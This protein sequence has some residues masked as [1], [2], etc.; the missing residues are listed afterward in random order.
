MLRDGV[1]QFEGVEPAKGGG[2]V[3]VKGTGIP[4]V[5]VIGYNRRI[6]WNLFVSRVRAVV[7]GKSK[8][9]IE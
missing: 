8:A 9:V 2:Y 7:A 4:S 1:C 6:D 5:Q 3:V